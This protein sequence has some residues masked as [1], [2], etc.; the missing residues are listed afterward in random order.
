MFLR[1]Y[2]QSQRFG[3]PADTVARLLNKLMREKFRKHIRFKLMSTK[4]HRN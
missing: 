2:F 3:R 1:N 4:L